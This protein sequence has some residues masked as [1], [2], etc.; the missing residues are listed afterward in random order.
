MMDGVSSRAEYSPQVDSCSSVPSLQSLTPLHTRL[1]SM[2][3]PDT[4]QWN[5]CG[6]HVAS[7]GVYSVT[8]I[9]TVLQYT[10]TLSSYA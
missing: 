2:H 4:I 6:P 1:P 9:P 8:L 7:T 10:S 5:W 3:S